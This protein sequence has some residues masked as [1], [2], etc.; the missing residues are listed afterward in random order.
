MFKDGRVWIGKSET[1]NICIFPKMA[2]RHGLIAGA[3]GTGKTVTLKVL[4]ESFSDAGVPV[5]LADAKGDIAGMCKEG[6]NSEDMIK[7]MEYFGLAEAGFNFDSYPVNFWDVYGEKGMPLRT[8]ISEMGPLLLS[9]LM[10]LNDVQTDILNVVF[11]IADDNGLLL[12]DTKDLKKML[13]FVSDNSKEFSMEYGNV[14]ATSI[15]AIVRSVVALETDG[16]EQFFAEPALNIKDW[17]AIDQRGKGF[18]QILDCQKLMLNPKTYSM[19]LLWMIS[20][21]FET[22]PEVGDCDKPKMVFFFDEAHMLFDG[23]SKVLLE[24]IEQVVKLIRSKGVGIYFVT[25]NPTD[26]PDG[27]LSQLGNKIQHAL[28]A[29]TPNE[30][31]SMKAVAAGF[32]E[33]P[34]F[35][36]YTAL[37]ELGTGEALI[38][39]LGED[40]VPTMVERAKI[41]PPASYMGAIDEGTRNEKINNS[42]LYG[43]YNYFVDNESAYERLTAMY[44]EEE[45]K[46]AEEKAAAEKAK[47]EKKAEEA[48]AKEEEKAKAAE[49]K[50]K[51]AEEKA[52]AA[53][54][55][56]AEKE[57][58]KEAARLEKEE[59]AA[60]AKAE[61]EAAKEAARLEK[62][63]AKEQA[64]LEKEE[65]KKANARKTAVK[66]ATKGVASSA[67]GTIGREL[68]NALGS[69]VGGTF[70]KK[71]GGNLGA[72]LGR[73]II[74]TLFKL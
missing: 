56:K 60:A 24:K 19:F 27:V 20:E 61:R 42:M 13:Q 6:V 67:A 71:L 3:T 32:R 69:S 7:R 39:V 57:A 31:K 46:I 66:N 54:E 48:A 58:A 34:A 70:G 41:L 5:F 28:H 18:I 33:N 40:G 35:D 17:M 49:E 25:Q 45:Q 29:Y 43:K 51:A 52:K 65:A 14:P 16:G 62:E 21:L 63:E 1:D 11:K 26:I 50:A 68:G 59:A 30:Q 55:A 23:A 9:R 10:G 22:L 53:E 74:G 2:N 64:R 4:A 38:S 44:S 15:A 72:S 12:I 73:G 8:T 47:E 37:G 36:T